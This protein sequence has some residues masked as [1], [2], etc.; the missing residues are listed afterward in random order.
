L[1]QLAAQRAPLLLFDLTRERRAGVREDAKRRLESLIV[2]EVASIERQLSV[3]GDASS[4][5]RDGVDVCVLSASK[6][7]VHILTTADVDLWSFA[8]ALA[9]IIFE[10]RANVSTVDQAAV[11]FTLLDKSLDFLRRLGYPVDS[12]IVSK[13]AMAAAAAA[14]HRRMTWQRRRLSPAMMMMSLLRLL[15][16]HCSTTM[17]TCKRY[18]RA[19][20]AA[21]AAAKA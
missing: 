3:R 16:H 9:T 17:Q 15:P 20:A 13:D 10:A 14:A 4:M 19:R 1:V 5:V 8:H 6:S 11:I 7:K 2:E 21:P 18:M 12:L